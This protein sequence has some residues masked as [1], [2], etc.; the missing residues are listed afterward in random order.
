[1]QFPFKRVRRAIPLVLAVALLA[2]SCG[3]DD[4][5]GGAADPTVPGATA[6]GPTTTVVETPVVGGEATALLFSEILTLDPVKGTGSGGSDGQRMHAIFG[7]LITIDGNTGAMKPLQAESFKLKNPADATAWQIKLRPG[8]KFTD[9]TVV[10]RERGQGQLGT[11]AGS[12]QR[13]QLSWRRA[14]GQ[15]DDRR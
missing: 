2:A 8:Q 7:G 3:G 1:M 13:V 12:G 11:G 4:K 9:G 10:R 15:D 14:V 6:G 5:E